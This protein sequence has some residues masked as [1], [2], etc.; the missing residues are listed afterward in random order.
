MRKPKDEKAP[1]VDDVVTARV[2]DVYDKQGVIDL[3][4]DDRGF[5]NISDKM[6]P[7]YI[8]AISSLLNA[9]QGGQLENLDANDISEVKGMFNRQIRHDQQDW[10]QV[11]LLFGQPSRFMANKVVTMLVEL[12]TAVLAADLLNY[13]DRLEL[14]KSELSEELLQDVLDKLCESAVID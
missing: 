4:I 14:L 10:F 9:Y 6:R 12:R 7:R 2:I 11:A 1:N 5:R 8:K 3:S 13:L